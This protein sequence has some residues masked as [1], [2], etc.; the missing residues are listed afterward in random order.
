[1][2]IWH[3][4]CFNSLITA[5]IFTF[6]HIKDTWDDKC[7]ANYGNVAQHKWPAIKANERTTDGRNEL[8][9]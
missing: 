5:S 9:S 7:L 8:Q 6:V 2:V 3:E 4:T 1:M